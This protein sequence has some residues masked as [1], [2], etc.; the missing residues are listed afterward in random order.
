MNDSY[1]RESEK[2]GTAGAYPKDKQIWTEKSY[3]GNLEQ[4]ESRAYM[5]E[6]LG[7]N[8]EPALGTIRL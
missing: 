1:R 8:S 3:C 5:K 6:K 4:S 7:G 2:T